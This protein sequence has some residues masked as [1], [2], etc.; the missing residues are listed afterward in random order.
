MIIAGHETTLNLITNAVRALCGNR[1]Q[2]ELVR[3][4]QASW[5]GLPVCGPGQARRA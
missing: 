1:A 4:G 2:L 3:S 5:G